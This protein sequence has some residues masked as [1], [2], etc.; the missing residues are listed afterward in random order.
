MKTIIKGRWWIALAWIVLISGLFYISPN[1]ADLVREKGKLEVPEGY[2]SKIASHMITEAQGEVQGKKV[3]QVALVFHNEQKLTKSEIQ[4]VEKAIRL[5]EQKKQSLGIK[6]LIT[7]FN[8]SQLKDQLVSKD[9]KSILVSMSLSWGERELSTLNDALVN[10]L[11]SVK[12]KHYFTSDWMITDQLLDASQEGVKKTEG[13]TVVFILLVLLLVFRS[14]VAP[15]IPLVTVGVSYLASQSIVSILVDSFDFPISTNTQSFLIAV[16]FGIGTDYCILLLSR[17][18]EELSYNKRVLPSIVTT[19]K[20]AGRTVF[21][22]ALAVMIGFAAIGFSEF[23]LYQS[24][25]AVAVGVGVL[26]IALFT[27]VPFFMAVLGK[28]IFWPSKQLEHKESRL[29]GLAGKFSLSRPV[30]SLLLVA[31]ICVPFIFTYNGKLSFNSLEEIGDNATSI[32]AFNIISASFGSGESM[33]T[34]VV[35]KNDD[36]MDSVEYFHVVEKMSRELEKV[37]LVKSVRSITRPVGEPIE[38][39]LIAKQSENL[40]KGLGEGKE[41]VSKISNGLQQ[42]GSEL[43]K[44]QPELKSATKGINGLINGTTQVKSGLTEIQTNLTEIENGIRKG[45]MGSAEVKKGLEASKTGAQK[46]LTGYQELLKGYKEVGSQLEKLSSG[47]KEIGTGL[48]SIS[49][50]LN[51]IQKDDFTRLESQYEGLSSDGSYQKIKGTVLTVQKPLS[52][53]DNSLEQLNTGLTKLEKGVVSANKE[54]QNAN[55]GQENIVNGLEQLIQGIDQQK[56]GLEQLAHGQGQIVNHVPRLTNGLSEITNGQKKLRNGFRELGDQIGQLTTGLSESAEGLDKVSDGLGSAQS[57]LMGLSNTANVDGF[58]M[59]EDV[60]ENKDFIKVLDAYLSADRKTMTM[61]V[62]FETNPYSRNT[63]DQVDKI[64]DAVHRA[65]KGTK[66]ENA[67][68]AVGGISSI[69]ADLNTMSDQDYSRTVI[70]MLLGI[71]VI[72]VFLFRSIVMP[73]YTIGSLVLTYYTTMAINEVIFVDLLGYGGISWAVPF[74]GFVILMAL[75]VDYSIFLM[76]RFNEYSDL[77][78]EEAMMLSMKKMGTVIISAAIILGGTFAAMIPSGMLSLIQV[79]SIILIGLLLYT[80]VVLPLFI[81]VLV[82]NFGKANWWPFR[83]G[84]PE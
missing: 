27:L 4:E 53:L 6:K 46:L 74:F 55:A 47:Y 38:E 80:F 17:F 62:V 7:H 50:A 51:Q 11:Q 21:F 39:F 18:K 12:V 10:T 23:K 52:S 24:A 45:T 81:P 28:T 9:G 5:L 31:V 61:D 56:S 71:G 73:L 14:V 75:G 54:F 40:E 15:I 16:L 79:A 82:K 77:S 34:K 3:T 1:M 2:S 59:P 58:Y 35:L 13:I 63:M 72:L 70:L 22:S 83:R 78:V 76:D 69:N 67:T 19:Y 8:E 32:K 41:G 60:L 64:K 26:L 57:Y 48:H 30:V 42:A 20:N 36:R 68:V 43:S 84:N 33:P 29:W 37:D 25:S 65:T 44:S 66:L 49:S